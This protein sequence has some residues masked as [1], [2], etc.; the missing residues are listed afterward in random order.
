MVKLTSD[1]L[2]ER[3][4]AAGMKYLP[5]DQIFYKH[6]PYKVELSPKFKGLGG[7]SGKRGCQIDIS[8]PVKARQKLAE[9]NEKMDRTLCNVEY[10]LEIKQF[11]ER[12]PRAEFK[13]RMGGENNLFY[14]RDPELVMILVE[15]YRDV[16]NSV[17]GPIN[18]EHQ[19]VLDERNIVMREKLYYDRYRYVLEYKFCEE[20]V[21]T[22][23][24]IIDYLKD[25]DA[26]SWRAHRLETC[27]RFFEIHSAKT[28][29]ARQHP[30]RIGTP[31]I[32]SILHGQFTSRS[33][34]PEKIQLYLA[35]GND[36]VYIKLL[37]AEH[38]VA[39]HEVMLFD[40][41]T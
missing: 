7:V 6:Y 26:K 35:D 32:N 29:V 8:D 19:D 17:T 16:I 39:N 25:L 33:W 38:V 9:F 31:M 15:R 4:I 28:T 22:A 23:R 27:V 11:V 12:L 21:N 40:E 14:F 20:F 24:Q 34:A 10:R 13:T 37:S 36:Y 3:V 18:S 1:E 2:R 5:A 41:L 30:S